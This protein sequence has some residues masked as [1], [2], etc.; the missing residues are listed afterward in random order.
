MDKI[1]QQVIKI[2]S[3]CLSLD[4]RNVNEQC[5]LDSF[6]DWSSIM[7]LSV[8]AQIEEI[9]DIK[10]EAEVLFDVETVGDLINIVIAKRK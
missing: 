2:V 1:N 10:I 7:Y 8:I 9:F 5:A 3:D 6:P 4:R